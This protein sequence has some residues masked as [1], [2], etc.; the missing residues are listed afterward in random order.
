MPRNLFRGILGLVLISL[1]PAE[2]QVRREIRFPDLP[3]YQTLKADLHTH[4]VFSDGRVWPTVRVDEAWREGLDVL[5]ITD[6]IEHKPFKQDV[7]TDLNRPHALAS[8]PA[9]QTN[10]LLIRGAEITRPTPPGHFNAVFLEDANA[11][12]IP[13]FYEVFDEAARQKTFVF[14][15]HPGWKGP[16]LGKW[17]P[18]QTKL[19]EKKQLHGIEICNGTKYFVEAHQYAIDHDLVFIGNSDLH[20]PASDTERTVEGHRTITLVFA[21]ERTLEGVREALFAGR[22]IV[23]HGNLLIG[24]EEFLAPFFAACLEIRPIHHRAGRRAWVEIRNHTDVTIELQRIG[25]GQPSQLTLEPL[26]TSLVTF[27]TPA[28]GDPQPLPYLAMNFLVGVDQ[29]LKVK[30]DISSKQSTRTASP[31]RELVAP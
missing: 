12:E 13:D 15:N 4:T 6:H 21:R 30:L 31:G 7:S 17:G 28:E 11:L 9:G 26:S 20:N 8:G 18:E 2:A 29:P 22:T 24:R 5:A 16:E 23:W 1:A 19:L 10:I 3:G 25:K 27:S 14:W